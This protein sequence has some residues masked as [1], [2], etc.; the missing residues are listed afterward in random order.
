MII[1]KI[2]FRKALG[3]ALNYWDH[4]CTGY[5]DTSGG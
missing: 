5:M 1:Q 4:N 3:D 2:D